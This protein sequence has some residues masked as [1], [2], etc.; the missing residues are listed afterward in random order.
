[1]L[2]NVARTLR[3]RLTKIV[4]NPNTLLPKSHVGPGLQRVAELSSE[5][6]SS[7]VSDH[8]GSKEANL[9]KMRRGAVAWIPWLGAED[10]GRPVLSL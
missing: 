5:F 9:I 2:G 10:V 3:A 6:S 8:G 4:E 7:K 1:M